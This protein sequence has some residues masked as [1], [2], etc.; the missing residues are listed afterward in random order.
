MFSTGLYAVTIKIVPFPADDLKHQ[1]HRLAGFLGDRRDPD[2]YPHRPIDKLE[3]D[4]FL[5]PK[6]PRNGCHKG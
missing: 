6:G 1:Q 2:Y 3:N 4:F 5:G